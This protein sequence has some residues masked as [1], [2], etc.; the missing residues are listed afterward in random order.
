MQLWFVEDAPEKAW[1]TIEATAKAFDQL[2]SAGKEDQDLEKQFA[3]LGGKSVDAE[4]EAMKAERQAKLRP[5]APYLPKELPAP[6]GS[7]STGSAAGEKA[8]A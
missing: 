5:P 4:L 2:A 1:S 3:S 7:A 6:S 8:K